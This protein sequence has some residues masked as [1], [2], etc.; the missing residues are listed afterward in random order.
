MIQRKLLKSIDSSFL[1]IPEIIK[2]KA[3]LKKNKN[4]NRFK[5]KIRKK[6][7]SIKG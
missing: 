1:L 3:N 4:N 2:N 7:I 6:S 5:E